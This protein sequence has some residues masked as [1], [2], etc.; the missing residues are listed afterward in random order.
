MLYK[1][2]LPRE[3]NRE[4]ENIKKGSEGI[5]DCVALAAASKLS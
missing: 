5:S 4:H 3:K 1:P 2:V